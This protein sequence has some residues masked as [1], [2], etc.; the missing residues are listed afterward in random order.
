M[1]LDNFKK[2]CLPTV[3]VSSQ[4]LSLIFWFDQ[5]CCAR[6]W[7]ILRAVGWSPSPF[8]TGNTLEADLSYL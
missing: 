4:F 5:F 2:V 6:A 7:F 1:I 8:T 3:Y